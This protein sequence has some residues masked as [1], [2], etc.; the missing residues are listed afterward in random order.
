[1]DSLKIKLNALPKNVKNIHKN[2][3]SYRVFMQQ[4][5]LNIL[6]FS[7]MSFSNVQAN[8]TESHSAQYQAAEQLWYHT[9]T[10][11]KPKKVMY[12]NCQDRENFT[13]QFNIYICNLC[14]QLARGRIWLEGKMER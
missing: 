7:K 10:F 2:I 6:T 9:V 13:F 14:R 5:M 4:W 8:G 3:G 12:I 11:A 1:M